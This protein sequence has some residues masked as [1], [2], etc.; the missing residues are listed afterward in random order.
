M[1]EGEANPARKILLLCLSERWRVCLSAGPERKKKSDTSPCLGLALRWHSRNSSPSC[2][3][4][5]NYPDDQFIYPPP[6]SFSVA[7]AFE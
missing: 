1:L 5:G 3:R 4:M 7:L 6:L 2:A